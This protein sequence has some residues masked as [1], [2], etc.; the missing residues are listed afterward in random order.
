MDNFQVY[1]PDSMTELV[2][3]LG[4][5]TPNSKILAGGTDLIISLHERKIYP[6]LIIDLSGVKELSSIKEENG[7]VSLGAI[8]T[9]TEIKEN[10]LVQKYFPSL[11]EAAAQVGSNQ[12]RNRA[13]IGGNIANAS[14]AGDSLPVLSMLN[15][16][17]FVINHLGNMKEYTIDEIVAAPRKTNLSYHEAI[18][19]IKIPIPPPAFRSAFVKLGT[20]TAVTIA[21]INVA[22]GINYDEKTRR[23]NEACLVIG[24]ISPKPLRVPEIEKIFID[25]PLDHSLLMEFSRDLSRLVEKTAPVEFEMEYKKDAVNGVALDL[26][27]K[28][29]PEIYPR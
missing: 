20:R 18:V 26:M 15:A 11:A 22:M 10:S 8:T 13:T 3:A 21:M 5:A 1:T 25:R 29:L 7:W 16:K 2:K 6:D 27:H 23:V 24:A 17:V 19:S 9:F 14:P 28:L 4:Q 12:I